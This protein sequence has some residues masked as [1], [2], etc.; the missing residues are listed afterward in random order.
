MNYDVRLLAWIN[1]NLGVT[2]DM[3]T[4]KQIA[5]WRRLLMKDATNFMSHAFFGFF[6]NRIKKTGKHSDFIPDEER[7]E[8]LCEFKLKLVLASDHKVLPLKLPMFEIV[9][10]D[11]LYKLELVD[12]EALCALRVVQKIVENRRCSNG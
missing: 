7:Y 2:H 11:N 9:G 10:M 1:D 3:L 8:F 4:S 6:M 5:T 12:E